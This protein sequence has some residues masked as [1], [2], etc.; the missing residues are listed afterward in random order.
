[1][2]EWYE[3]YADYRDTMARDRGPRATVAPR[4]LGT[5]VTLPR[6][7]TRPAA[8]LERGPL[9]RVARGARLW[10]RTR[11]SSAPARTS[12]RRHARRHGLAAARRPRVQPLRRADAIE[13][14]IVHDYPV[15]LSPV[16]AGP[17]TTRA[18]TERFEY[19][20]GGWSSATPSRRST[21]REQQ[22]ARSTQQRSRRGRA[23]RP[24]YVE[25]SRTA[26]RRRAASG[27]GSTGSRCC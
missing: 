3:A 12:A 14:T 5:T 13:P 10:T 2:L 11:R 22:R 24:D 16:R 21:T 15:E 27:S 7:P 4:S 1:M 9:R 8:A 19:F 18:L 25:R 26:C 20:A 6:A 17:T 23:R